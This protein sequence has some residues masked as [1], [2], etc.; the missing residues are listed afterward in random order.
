MSELIAVEGLTL[1]H[2]SGSPISG[3]SFTITSTP[4]AKV[5]AE[6][7]GV[8]VSPLAFSFSGGDASGFVAGSVSGGGSITATA[9]K[10]Q[11]SGIAVMRLGDSVLMNCVGTIDPPATPPTGPVSGN[12]EITDAGQTKVEAA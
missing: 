11:A 2:V 12:V 9:V 5:K 7:H 4:D 1:D 10:V 6:G 8:Y 3:G